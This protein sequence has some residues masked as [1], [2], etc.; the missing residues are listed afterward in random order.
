[1]SHAH[2]QTRQSLSGNVKGAIAFVGGTASLIINDTLVKIA[3]TGLPLGQ[4]IFV[5][6]LFAVAFVYAVVIYSGLGKQMGQMKQ[7][8]VISRSVVNMF[9][10]FAYISTL[11]NMPIANVSAIMQTVPLALTAAAAIV[12]GEQVGIRRWMAIIVGLAG[13]LLV[14]KPG[15]GDFNIYVLTASAAVFLVT[16]RDLLTRMTKSDVPSLIITLATAIAVTVGSGVLTL[17]EDWQP[18]TAGTVLTLAAAAAFLM[19]G[20]HLIVVAVRAGELSVIAPFRY[21][22]IIWALLAGYLVWGEFPDSYAISGIVLITVAGAYTM[23]R[24]TRVRGRARRPGFRH[25]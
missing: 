6:G 4:L 23:W 15:A 7:P 1:M 3:G 14:V 21:F 25:H 9:A 2:P 20:L 13:V 5:R 22:F 17:F 24:E 10:M 8:I 11:L 18:M 19:L 16:L 12:L